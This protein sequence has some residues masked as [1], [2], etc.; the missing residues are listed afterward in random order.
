MESTDYKNSRPPRG[1][2]AVPLS[3]LPAG[4]RGSKTTHQQPIA[5]CLLIPLLA[6]HTV[7]MGREMHVLDTAFK[8]L[9]SHSCAVTSVAVSWKADCL[10]SILFLK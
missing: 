1:W 4:H 10:H 7:L 3:P 9:K 6:S 8:E 5:Y 2:S